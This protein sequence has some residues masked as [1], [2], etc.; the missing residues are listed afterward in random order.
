MINISDLIVTGLSSEDAISVMNQRERQLIVNSSI[1]YIEG[2]SLVTDLTWDR[3]AKHLQALIAEYPEEFKH[4]EFATSFLGWDATTG[5]K[6]PITS[7]WAME[8]AKLLLEISKGTL[9]DR[10]IEK[11]LDATPTK[12][13]TG[14][15]Q[16]TGRAVAAKKKKEPKLVQASLF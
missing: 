4:T 6:L 16:N 3:W 9:K 13:P 5:F 15:S 1:Y 2:E 11:K 7:S 10:K 12:Y 8:K 14:N